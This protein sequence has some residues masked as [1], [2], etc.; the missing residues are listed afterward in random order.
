MAKS[1]SKKALAAGT[2][3]ALAAAIAL[4]GTFAWQSISQQ[5]KNEAMASVNPGGR[6]HDDFNGRN[7]DIYV[8]NFTDPGD[9]TPIFARV[10]LD[11]YMEIGAGAGLKT[12]DDGFAEKKAQS[13]EDG[14]KIDDVNT[15]KTHIPGAD[16]K[17]D[18]YWNWTTGGQTTYMPTFNKNKD[19]LVADI[20]GTYEGSTP[21]DD[22]HYD[23]YKEW[24][25]DEQKT[26][27]AIYD[28]D[29]NDIDEGDLAQEGIN[30]EKK[31]ETHT[32]ASTLTAEVMTMK[33]WM[34]AGS[35]PGTYWVWD[36]DGWAYWAQPIQ[37]GEATGLLLDGIELK[38]TFGDSWYYGINVVGQFVT[39]DDLG[40]KDK[41]GFYGTGEEPTENAEKL[42]AKIGA[43]VAPKADKVTISVQGDKV[44]KENKTQFSAKVSLNGADADSQEVT[45][46]LTGN[47]SSNTTLSQ[48]GLLTVGADE[49]SQSLTITAIHAD[50]VSGEL[51]DSKTV[52][53]R[54]AVEYADSI[55]PGSTDT[56]TIDGIEFY[57]LAKDTPKNQALLI[58]KDIQEEKAFDTDSPVWNGSDMQ[59]YLNRDWLNSK[60]NLKLVAVDTTLHT[61]ST[62]DGEEFTES[63]DKVFLLSEAD[64]FGTQNSQL[65]QPQD[66]TYGGKQLPAPGD[67]WI[68]N[69]RG[70]SDWYWL[71][72]PRGGARDVSNVDS[73]GSLGN[74]NYNNSNSGI[75]PVLWVN[76]S[77]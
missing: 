26:A 42:L 72:S 64:V 24:K 54:P 36:E 65:A 68:A 41:T 19:S 13:L 55:T 12:D 60:T 30:I 53:V 62:F 70:G 77:K 37:P 61:R 71:R 17:F 43:K 67:S 2:A 7:K 22:T 45:W 27:D 5:A 16:N 23:D 51:T 58:T 38:S 21:S 4:T 14:A 3:V 31:E 47:S 20:N 10:R 59:I 34:D 33:E 48:N 28:T 6:L 52:T 1:K 29:T 15:W 18:D 9:G 39:A 56:V 63:T 25:P 32:A 11:E 66:Y 46:K 49:A 73:S 75:R 74:I 44:Y 35:K 8:E 40:Q 57:V 76:L 69:H 50:F